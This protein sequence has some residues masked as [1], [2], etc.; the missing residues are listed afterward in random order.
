[1]PT[2]KATAEITVGCLT[3]VEVGEAVSELVSKLSEVKP[4][5]K[6]PI[7][8]EHRTENGYLTGADFYSNGIY[9][10]VRSEILT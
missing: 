9:Y 7:V 4:G 8:I 10:K 6:M 2:M 5:D 1:M 3:L